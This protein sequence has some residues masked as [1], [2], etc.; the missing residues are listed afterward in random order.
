MRVEAMAE[1]HLDVKE[2]QGPIPVGEETT[3]EVRVHNRGT[4]AAQDIQVMAYFS[5]G[6]EPT[7]AEGC[8]HR[9]MPG[10][11]AFN[12]IASLPAGEEVT[13][14]VRACADAVGNHIFRAEVHCA[15]GNTLGQRRDHALLSGRS[16]TANG[17]SALCPAAGSPGCAAARRPAP[18]LVAAVAA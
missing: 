1:L 11:V 8:P 12:P 6:I 4:K 18:R 15:A 16:A 17:R 5:Q 10:Q 3:Y 14:K 9:I 2:P 7:S 13:L